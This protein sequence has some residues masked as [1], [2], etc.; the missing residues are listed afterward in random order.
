MLSGFQTWEN[1]SQYAL[2]PYLFI[3]LGGIYPIILRFFLALL[4]N[5][6][7]RTSLM[8]AVQVW[9]GF[10]VAIC[11]AKVVNSLCK[12]E[13]Y[14]HSI[15]FTTSLIFSAGFYFGT[16]GKYHSFINSIFLN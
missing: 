15:F 9:I 5:L 13:L 7:S 8:Y 12:R 6:W 16:T 4:F 11:A 1:A 3:I 10:C 14:F 2:R